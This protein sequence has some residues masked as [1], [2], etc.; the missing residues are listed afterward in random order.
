MASKDQTEPGLSSAVHLAPDL[1]R[2]LLDPALTSIEVAQRHNLDPLAYRAAVR[3]QAFRAAAEA[4]RDA[5]QERT[6]L[7]APLMHTRAVHALSRIA[8][9]PT[10]TPSQT[11]S[12]RRACAALLK[13]G[14]Q[15]VPS[16]RGADLQSASRAQPEPV[17]SC[18]A[19]ALNPLADI[20]GDPAMT[21]EDSLRLI[22]EIETVRRGPPLPRGADVQSARSPAARLTARAGAAP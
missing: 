14:R 5:D 11:E 16:S 22:A 1:L 2:D 9:Q 20:A 13:V 10:T 15:S 8:N 21:L 7:L 4:L 3:S 6:E 18:P 12:A 17:L 19:P